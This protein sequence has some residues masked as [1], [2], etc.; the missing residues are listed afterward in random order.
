MQVVLSEHHSG[1]AEGIGLD[2]IATNFEEV[3]VNFLDYVRSA[4]NQQ[5][6]TTLFA[7][8]IVDSG[9]AKLDVSSHGAVVDDNALRHGME[10]VRHQ[11]SV[12]R[13]CSTLLAISLGAYHGNG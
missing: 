13:L 7:P 12:V 1:C 6:V 9:I 5:F 2:Y 11:V 3:R 8:E 4:Q 10:K